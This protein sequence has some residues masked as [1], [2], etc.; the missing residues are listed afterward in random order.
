MQ[1]NSKRDLVWNY[2]SILIMALGG[3][4][5][6][7]IILFFYD[8]ETLGVFNR[9]YAYYIVLSQISVCG[10]HMS[11][12][13]RVSDCKYDDTESRNWLAT[14]LALVTAISIA[15]ILLTDG[16]L[17]FVPTTQQRRM[18]LICI[19]PA[20]L[21]FSVNKV[22]L[23][24]INARVRMVAYAI[25]QAL[26][27][28]LI[29]V[30][31]IV[32]A[33]MRI[34]GAKLTLAFVIGEL[35]LFIAL[36]IYLIAQKEIGGKI[37]KGL[38]SDLINFGLKILPSNIVLELNTKVDVLCLGWFC[39]D[40]ALIG[41]YSFVTL[42]T[43]GFYQVYMVVRRNINPFLSE[44][45]KDLP[46]WKKEYGKW[47][48]LCLIAALPLSLLLVA[49][50]YV[51]ILILGKTEFTAGLVPLII[52]SISIAFNGVFIIYGNVMS[53][54][55]NPS[56]ESV[57]NTITVAVNFTLNIILI[58]LFGVTGA[59]I[60]TALSYCCFSVFIFKYIRKV[61]EGRI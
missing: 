11:V 12:L 16:V 9:A 19:A 54:L 31:I 6:S 58:I 45:S 10:I 13:K 49:A 59:A 44:W 18:S 20:L 1:Q 34:E 57:A 52:I 47:T 40:E 7:T 36:F 4:L 42:F 43:E 35:I 28:I 60:A 15:V 41:I 39:S 5:F 61:Q 32:L 46:R 48:K 22:L 38:A 30:G 25:F 27:N 55:G 53:Q 37:S 8:N 14:S 33:V 2:G 21:F 29:C 50:Y 51:L 56:R 26:R 24:Y 17:Q 3:L 23:N